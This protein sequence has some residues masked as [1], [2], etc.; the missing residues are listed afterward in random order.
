MIKKRP[1]K[2]AGMIYAGTW[3]D[4]GKKRIPR[5]PSLIG[6]KRKVDVTITTFMG[7]APGSR[8]WTLKIQEQNNSFWSESKNA[9]VEVCS[10]ACT[11]GFRLEAEV[12]TIEQAKSI[13]KNF[14]RLMCGEKKSGHEIM[15]HGYA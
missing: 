5:W 7:M 14:L 1:N 12:F 3:D 8:H 13:A 9:W 15:K 10:S 11:D 2:S 6:E 4:V